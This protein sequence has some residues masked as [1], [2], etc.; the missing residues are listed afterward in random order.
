MGF[1]NKNPR[2]LFPELDRNGKL[3]VIRHISPALDQSGVP[4]V[5]LPRNDLF[6]LH[7]LPDKSWG[8]NHCRR[9][10]TNRDVQNEVASAPIL[11]ME[12]GTL[13]IRL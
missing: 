5:C 6:P 4:E 12:A 3:V 2:R 11:D 13:T 1:A 7:Q 8:C 10:W 9:K